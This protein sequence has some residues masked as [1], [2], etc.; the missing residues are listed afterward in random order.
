MANELALRGQSGVLS[1]IGTPDEREYLMQIMAEQIG[2]PAKD[3][4]R[5]DV[6]ALLGAMV[7]RTMQYGWVPGIHAHVQK[8]ETERSREARK[9]N[10]NA[11]AV[12]SYTLV[13]GEKAYKDSGTRW[14]DRGVQ[15]RYQRKP[16]SKEEVKE[17]ARLQGYTEALA[18]NSYGMWSR[19][20]ILGQDDPA[21]DFD[22]LW[23]VGMYFGKIKAGKYWRDDIIPTGVSSRDIAI[24][25]ADKRAMMQSTL[26]LLPVDDLAP[27]QRIVK[28]VDDLRYE[29]N[30][31]ERA[32]L[33]LQAPSKV[34]Y[35]DDGDV[36]WASTDARPETSG[37]RL[38]IGSPESE[39]VDMDGE[40]WAEPSEEDDAPIEGGDY[41]TLTDPPGARPAVSG[42][43]PVN[44]S[45]GPCP[46][47][48]APVGK[49]HGSGCTATAP[50]VEAPG[51][52]PEA[53]VAPAP[54]SARPEAPAAKLSPL[55]EKLIGIY[56]STKIKDI[57]EL[58][59]KTRNADKDSSMKMSDKYLDALTVVIREALEFADK[60]EAY[61]LLTA[62]L[63][64]PINDKEKPGQLVHGFLNKPLRDR[65]EKTVK[66]LTALYFAV[67]DTAKAAVDGGLPNG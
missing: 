14:R 28:L 40:V 53:P 47:C 37:A 6:I 24:R 55:E 7:Q 16:M 36:L 58:M 15:W 66:A 42:A 22:P 59:R 43:R 49:V 41:A 13:D 35:E 8:F 25:R 34:T 64:Y 56:A 46:E 10:P 18:A 19:I 5:T 20:I 1:R 29:H 52:R 67:L 48:H 54:A 32:S 65:E 62:L 2:I 3:A 39:V 12:Y 21:D 50:T 51:A 31:R 11:E 26:T 9:K 4:N 38:Q 30:N 45:D 61:M 60:D 17:E 33:P 44:N 57:K 23:S 27:Q 63:G